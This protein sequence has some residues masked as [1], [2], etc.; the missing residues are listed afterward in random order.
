MYGLDEIKAMNK[1]ADDEATNNNLKKYVLRLYENMGES[2]TV[3]LEG[4]LFFQPDIK[5]NWIDIEGPNKVK[6]TVSIPKN[7]TKLVIDG[8]FVTAQ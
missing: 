2:T 3:E 1:K 6:I 5:I 8:D 4:T 7:K